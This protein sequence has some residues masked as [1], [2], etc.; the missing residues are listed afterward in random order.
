MPRLE[1]SEVVSGNVVRSS[2]LARRKGRMKSRYIVLAAVLFLGHVHPATAQQRDEEEAGWVGMVEGIETCLTHRTPL[3][4]H[5]YACIGLFSTAC[6]RHVENQTTSG[7]ERCYRDEFRAWEVLLN[8]YYRARPRG[9]SADPLQQV[10]RAWLAYR[11]RKCE[12][13]QTHYD[14]GSM[15]RWLGAQCMMDTTARRAIELRFLALDR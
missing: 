2:F 14:G 5:G 1:P 3:L 4:T 6:L 13:F 15:A 7:M 8:R 10:Q 11:D 9:G 12:Y